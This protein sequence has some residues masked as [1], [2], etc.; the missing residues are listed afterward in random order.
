MSAF[1]FLHAADI[2][3]DSP[4]AGLTRRGTIPAHV[5]QDCTRRA[6]AKLVNLAITEEVAF[7]IIAGDLY[8]ADQRDFNTAL[9][10]AGEMRRLGRPCFLVRGNHDAASVITR[11]LEPPPNVRVFSARRPESFYVEELGVAIHGQSFPH[12]AVPEDLSDNYPRAE[13]GKLNIGVLHTSADDPGEHESYAPC[14][15][16]ALVQK[17]YDYWA[18]GHIHQRRVL[19]DKPAFVVFPGNIQGR[20]ARETGAKGCSLVEVRDRAIASVT[21]HT[22]DVLRWVHVRVDVDGTDTI[23]E[24]GARVRFRL[25]TALPAAEGLPLIVRITLEGATARHSAIVGDPDAI[26]AECRSAAAAISGDLHVERVSVETR[27]SAT[28]HGGGVESIAQLAGQFQAALDDPD[29]QARLLDEFRALAGQV[30]RLPS[31]SGFAPPRG[32]DD[33]L[34]LGDDA[35]HILA[36]A[37][38]GKDTR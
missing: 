16:S 12:R 8:D 29:I 18:L 27:P 19:R 1:R 4:L 5:T 32:P 34:A 13:T 35:W 17:G 20:H 15:V 38:S 6:F 14:D 11:V 22:T 36:N 26:H 21:P 23:A 31:R 30:P 37:L 3:L 25:A 28:D 24:I 2:H 10:F 9:F 33:L 7:V